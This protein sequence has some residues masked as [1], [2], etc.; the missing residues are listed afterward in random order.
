MFSALFWAVVLLLG[1]SFFGIS[2]KEIV[3]APST[4]ENLAYV[5]HLLKEC[6]AWV[7]GLIGH[8]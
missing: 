1:L 5:T 8:L 3:N 4:Q 7:A 6:L 2:V